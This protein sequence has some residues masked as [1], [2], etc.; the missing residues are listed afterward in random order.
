[1]MSTGTGPPHKILMIKE[2]NNNKIDPHQINKEIK[3]LN[4]HTG[5]PNNM[6][7]ENNKLIII[8]HEANGNNFVLDINTILTQNLIIM[9]T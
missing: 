7:K 3:I 9:P 4:R 8:T 1:M 5:N 2:H 6:P